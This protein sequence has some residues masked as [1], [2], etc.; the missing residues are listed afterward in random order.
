M[1][2][3]KTV[4]TLT[5]AEGV[6]LWLTAVV[7]VAVADNPAPSRGAAIAVLLARGFAFAVTCLIGLYLADLYDI[8]TLRRAK[9]FPQRLPRALGVTLCLLTVL[10]TLY[11][12]ARLSLRTLLPCATAG[13]VLLFGMRA[14]LGRLVRRGQPE[15][16]L[17]LGEGA[18]AARIVD[19]VGANERGEHIIV[20][21]FALDGVGGDE[22]LDEKV[23]SARPDRIVVAALDR[24][25]L[26]PLRQ[27]LEGRLHGIAVEDWVPFYERLAGKIPLESLTPGSVAFGDGFGEPRLHALFARAVGLVAAL[28]G[29]IVLAPFLL[30]TALAIRLT[31]P[32]PVLF[33]QQRVGRY[34]RPY[35]L[36]KLRT[37]RVAKHAHSEWAQDNKKRVTPIGR[38]L[39]RFRI[40]ELPQLI[41]VLKGDMNLVGPRPHPVSNYLL[42]MARIP[43]YA[44]R[45]VVRPGITGWAQIRYGYANNLEQ[46]IEKMCFDLFYIRN[47]SI[48]LDLAVLVDTVRV[49]VRGHE[50]IDFAMLPLPLPLP[51]QAELS[52]TGT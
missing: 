12:G 18:L 16:V 34:G 3:R 15:R 10:Y 25:V 9:A 5:L 41:N 44:Q 19:A 47:V 37:M 35:G 8:A 24:E 14:A 50:G 33:V 22:P 31:S 52:G 28:I 29:L 26:L 17:V 6:V 45:S 32:G 13:I 42:F 23:R 51:V 30:L 11:P 4:L 40:D 48:W 36:I 27:L 7:G 1:L 21:V 43:H 39:R 38:W 2:T 49:V 46:E 20:G